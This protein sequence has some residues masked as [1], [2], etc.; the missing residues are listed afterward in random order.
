MAHVHD[1][2][3]RSRENSPKRD[4]LAMIVQPPPQLARKEIMQL[5]E[6]FSAKRFPGNQDARQRAKYKELLAR[7]VK[8]ESLRVQLDDVR[9]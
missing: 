2:I 3:R 7:V 8:S 6:A 1:K 9:S 5:G 4:G